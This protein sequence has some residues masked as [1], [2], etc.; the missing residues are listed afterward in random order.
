MILPGCVWKSYL[1][2][3]VEKDLNVSTLQAQISWML[4]AEGAWKIMGRKG[5]AGSSKEKLE[6]GSE[7]VREAGGTPWHP[8]IQRLT[9]IFIMVSAMYWRDIHHILTNSIK[10]RL[11][12][13]QI[14][15]YN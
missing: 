5:R 4:T 13:T 10:L 6:E 9:L 7:A 11:S 2:I 15:I 14:Y 3:F 12:H 1:S 8:K